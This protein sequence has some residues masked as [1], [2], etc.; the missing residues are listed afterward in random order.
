MPSSV[1]E[2]LREAQT[3][4]FESHSD[5]TSITPHFQVEY[6]PDYGPISVE[7]A[8]VDKPDISFE[9]ALVAIMMRMSD[10]NQQGHTDLHTKGGA[11]GQE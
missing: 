1:F 8:W 10:A 4:Q 2:P 3:E 5:G 9:F 11:E 7:L 6:H